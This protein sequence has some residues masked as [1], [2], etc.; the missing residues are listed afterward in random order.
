MANSRNNNHHTTTTGDSN[1]INIARIVI[2]GAGISGLTCARRLTQLLKK[3]AYQ[4]LIVEARDRI[5]GRTFSIP[6][7]NLDLGASWI[8][9]DHTAVRTLANELDIDMLEQYESGL[10]LIQTNSSNVQPINMGSIHGGVKRLKGGTNSLC[11]AMVRELTSGKESN[12]IISLNSPVVSID[13]TNDGIITVTLRDQHSIIA[14]Y[15]IL[16]LPPRL[17]LST[18]RLTPTLPS[19]VIEKLHKCVTWMAST[20][21]VILIYEH[22]WWRMRNFSGFAVSR[23][24]KA[25]EWH[26]ASSE[27]CNALFVFCL[28]GTTKQE[29]IDDTVRMFGAEAANPSAVHIADWSTEVFT[30]TST[31]DGRGSHPHLSSICRQA[32][33]NGRLWLSSSEVSD[34]D[35]GFLEGAVRRGIQVA[36]QLAMLIEI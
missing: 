16:A 34:A 25:Q 23:H 12:V 14:D 28:A 7:L 21:K 17:L 32:Q 19:T 24:S 11:T 18:I 27:T 10:S 22:A 5:G 20:C 35:G 6:E 3:Q 8:F 2:V 33:W 15:V 29:V 26:D 13:C 31:A 4:I 30:S 9:P 36:D 1:A